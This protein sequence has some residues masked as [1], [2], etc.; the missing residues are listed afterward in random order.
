[1]SP[2]MRL[3]GVPPLFHH[4]RY[5]RLMSSTVHNT[6]KACC[7]I[8]PVQVEYTPKGAYKSHGAFDTVYVTGPESSTNAIVAVFDIFGCVIS[9]LNALGIRTYHLPRFAAQTLQGADI[10]ATALNTR[11]Y[12]PDFFNGAPFSRDRF[13]PKTEKDKK[14]IQAFF[15]DPA[16]PDINAEK[17]KVF[18]KTLKEEGTY[19][20]VAAYGYCWGTS[21]S[22]NVP[23]NMMIRARTCFQKV[24]RSP[25]WLLAKM[26]PWMQQPYCTPGEPS[27]THRTENGKRD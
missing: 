25:C 11:I 6:N 18:V 1:M 8:P 12:M 27:I 5:Y 9:N 4:L 3:V 14:D 20:K 19:K 17:L 21:V 22:H 26:L 15:G 10:V 23:P 24:A 7:T 13:P 2:E 16:R